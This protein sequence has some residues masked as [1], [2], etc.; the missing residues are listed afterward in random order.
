[1][2]ELYKILEPEMKYYDKKN[3][4]TQEEYNKALKI[5][6][7]VYVGNLSFFTT[8]DSLWELFSRAGKI[9]EIIMGINNDGH[10]CGFCFVM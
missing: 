4:N 10:P 3:Y 2:A 1:M 7:T 6:T 8:Q 5:S 9:S